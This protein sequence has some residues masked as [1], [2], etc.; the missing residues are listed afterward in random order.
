M[1][2]A[3]HCGDEIT[4]GPFRLRRT[5]ADGAGGVY[6]YTDTRGRTTTIGYEANNA[7]NQYPN[8]NLGSGRVHDDRGNLIQDEQ[9]V[10]YEYD[11]ENRLTEIFTLNLLGQP[12]Y[13]YRLTYDALGR[14]IQVK[15]GPNPSPTVT[16]C[17]YDG[18]NVIGEF[19]ETDALQR[20][21]VHGPTY[22]DERIL[23][24]DE[25]S[26][27]DYYYLLKQLYTVSGLAN[28]NGQPVEAYAHD[29]Y[30]RVGRFLRIHFF[31]D[32]NHDGDVDF[33][34]FT[35]FSVCYGQP[36]QPN[37]EDA[38]WNG[39]GTI[40]QPD[41]LAFNTN[42]LASGTNVPCDGPNTVATTVTAS[43]HG[44]PYFFTG[45][46][47]EIVSNLDPNEPISKQLYYYRARTYDP[48]HGR[49]LQRDPLESVD[50]MNL[51]EYVGSRPVHLVDPLGTWESD[52]HEVKTSEWAQELGMTQTAA[53]LVGKE[54]IATDGPYGAWTIEM[55][56]HGGGTGF[57]LSTFGG[58]QSRHF[59]R[60]SGGKDTRLV[61]VETEIEA[62]KAACRATT[63]QFR[64]A[65]DAALHLGRA[66]H[67]LQDWWAHGD[68][69]KGPGEAIFAHASQYD[70]WGVDAVGTQSGTR[71]FPNGRAP[72]VFET[73]QVYVGERPGSY[74]FKEEVRWTN[75]R[76]GSLRKN[77]TRDDTKD[78]INEFLGSLIRDGSF[79]CKCFFLG[80]CNSK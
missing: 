44:N 67:S 12:V 76:S 52:V 53:D 37:C 17:Y 56:F 51:Y 27:D 36:A 65:T 18:Q 8:I 68:Y 40:G 75:W 50:G 14:R 21:F 45:R 20:S 77:G 42:R 60:S 46:R 63:N 41:W 35:H 1:M 22:I 71:A 73:R 78:K 66:L 15:K 23:I 39:D 4:S 49:F 70:V 24:H 6:G 61:W 38:D 13:K 26:D 74:R 10:H 11:F 43:E 33:S 30:G 57:T 54:N 5:F 29:A 32:F 9:Q 64:S 16:R 69:S 25:A 47:L 72:Q 62:A 80:W 31:G 3:A 28:E 55:I 34:D 48:F 58:D 59:N 79:P 7:A 2:P 19:D